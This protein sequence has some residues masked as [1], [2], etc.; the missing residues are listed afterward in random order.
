MPDGEPEH[1]PREDIL[2]Y[3]EIAWILSR[4]VREFGLRRVRITGGEPLVRPKLHVLISML[5]GL[6][7]EDIAITTNGQILARTIDALRDAGLNRVNVS[8]DSLRPET[9]RA[10]TGGDLSRTMEG[11]AALD[12]SGL[13][14]VKINTVVLRDHNDAEVEEIAEWA[15]R[16]GY[17]IR[18][19]E[20][21]AIGCVQNYHPTMFVPTAEVRDRLRARFD[22]EPIDAE[23]GSTARLWRMRAGDAVGTVGFISPET[24]PFCYGCR[25][26]RMT[27]KGTFLGCLMLDHGPSV[28]EA[29]RAPGGP[30]TRVFDEAVMTA[31]GMK[32]I[33]RLYAT[34]GHMMSIGG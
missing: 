5:S 19:L 14:P 27:A 20:L 10:M 29:I 12:R 7:L 8:L 15:V 25:R 33:H 17:E 22:M 18:F 28:R 2:T 23:D 3:E 26:L 6:G 9:F 13:R 11:I 32:P 21:M 30:D 31:V 4:L 1:A 16:L 34:N 24:E